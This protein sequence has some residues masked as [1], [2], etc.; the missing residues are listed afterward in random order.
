MDTL[1]IALLSWMIYLTLTVGS[2]GFL[3][4]S[5]EEILFGALFAV[6]TALL[7]K[8]LFSTTGTGFGLKYLNPIRWSLFLAYVLGPFFY[9]MAKANFDVAYRVITGK[10]KPGI[11]R[12]SPGLKTDFGLAMLANSI[13]LTP[14]T[15][16]VDVNGKDLYVHWI[17]VK[18]K[19]P[20][21]E[22]ICLSFPK[23]IRR[24]TE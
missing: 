23:W 4:W 1:I 12:I 10:I 20:K 8:K 3:L 6:L 21:T 11:V 16:T 22:E 5:P 19:E 14:G 2:G 17:Y 13:T 18:N 24:I 9:G 15:L 7:T